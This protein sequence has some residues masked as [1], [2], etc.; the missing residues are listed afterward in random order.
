M[1]VPVAG[2]P[3]VGPV[4]REVVLLWLGTLLAIRLVVQAVGTL[5]LPDLVLV[6]VPVLFMYAPVALCRA[7]G[8]DSDLYPLALPAF[9]DRASW[10]AAARLALA[11]V[12]VVALPYLA[13]YHLWQSWWFG[14]GPSGTLP[15]SMLTLVGY[16]LFFVAIPEEMFYRGYLQSRLDEVWAP[17]WR[18]LGADLGPGWLLTCALFAFGHSVVHFQWWH[19]A[20]FAPSL[21]FGWMRA[22]SGGIVAGALFH[23]WCNVTVTTLDTLYG[24]VPPG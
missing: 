6:L 22:R 14:L 9:R 4:L 7:R 21:V 1:S 23:A 12:A 8:V 19:F 20:I 17:R 16:H 18:I 24:I 15:S 10:L 13:A 5:G 2:S 11:V 3:A